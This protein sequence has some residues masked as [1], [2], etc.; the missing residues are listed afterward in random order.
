MVKRST[1]IRKIVCQDRAVEDV[2]AAVSEDSAL[3]TRIPSQFTRGD[4][5]ASMPSE[6]NHHMVKAM[7]VDIPFNTKESGRSSGC[8]DCGALLKAQAA[9][10]F[11]VFKAR[12]V[13]T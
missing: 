11:H 10:H 6:E 9:P 3:F 7:L 8:N 5:E 12:S 2:A 1:G 4:A 13:T